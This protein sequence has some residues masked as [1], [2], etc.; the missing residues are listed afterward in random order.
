MRSALAFGL[1]VAAGLILAR[2]TRAQ[3]VPVPGQL[4]VIGSPDRVA[5]GAFSTRAPEQAA[6]I[7]VNGY[8]GPLWVPQ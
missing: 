1:L 5:F 7:W 2:S 8:A 3:A 4:G 6:G